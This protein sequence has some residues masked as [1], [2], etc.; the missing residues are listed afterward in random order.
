[1]IDLIKQYISSIDLTHLF[2]ARYRLYLELVNL[3]VY[4]T[5]L[6]TYCTNPQIPEQHREH[7]PTREETN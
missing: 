4:H 6:A 2:I 7:K 3:D 5:I 1:M